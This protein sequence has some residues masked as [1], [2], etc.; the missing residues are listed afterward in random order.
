[1]YGK[2]MLE[3]ADAIQVQ[4]LALEAVSSLT[5]ALD[6]AMTSASADTMSELKR[7]VG[8]SI[9]TIETELLSVLYKLYPEIDDLAK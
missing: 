3:R 2:L 5:T 8:L 4:R 1:M 7:G 6:I 9:G